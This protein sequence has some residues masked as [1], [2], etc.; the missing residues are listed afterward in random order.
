MSPKLLWQGSGRQAL[1]SDGFERYLAPI[2][3]AMTKPGTDVHFVANAEAWFPSAA[4]HW[5]LRFPGGSC[6]A[7]PFFFFFSVR[8][9]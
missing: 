8:I 7:P 1:N 2:P 9:R 6:Y 4:L 5:L 3:G